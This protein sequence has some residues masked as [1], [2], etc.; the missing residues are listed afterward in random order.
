MDFG[1]ILSRSGVFFS[2]SGMKIV[3]LHRPTMRRI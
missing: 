3:R 2:R 1:I